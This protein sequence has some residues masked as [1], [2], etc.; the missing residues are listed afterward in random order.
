MIEPVDPAGDW[1]TAEVHDIR[2]NTPR[3]ATVRLA[4]ADRGR[5]VPGQ[6][7]LVRLTAA[8]GYTAAR[9]YSVCSSP[10]DPL[11]ELLIERFDEGE[12]SGYFT[13][14]ARPGDLVE[15]RGPIGGWFR[16]TGRDPAVG[17]G[18]GSGVAP[19]VSMVRHAREI[20]TTEKFTPV[21]AARTL[22]DVPYVDEFADAGA[23]FA[24]SRQDFAGRAAGRLSA[25]DLQPLLAPGKFSYVCG[26]S[27]FA[28]AVSQQLAVLGA[29][30]PKI[31]VQRFSFS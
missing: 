13:D 15:V 21:V 5:Q 18:G 17:I 12:V 6:H 31:R 10:S 14:I 22:A 1:R 11:L 25:A 29:E 4:V 2:W 30:V 16:W 7:Y 20:G 8:D 26:S 28:E 3:L 19:L 9:N 23:V 27:N 24:L